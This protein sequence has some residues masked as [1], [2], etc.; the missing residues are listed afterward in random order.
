MK[1]YI[2]AYGTLK[3]FQKHYYQFEMD[4]KTNYVYT[5]C[6]RKYKMYELNGEPFIIETE[7][8]KDKIVGDLF[9]VKD[10]SVLEPIC[11]RHFSDDY[12]EKEVDVHEY[13]ALTWIMPSVPEEA[14]LNPFGVWRIK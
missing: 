12:I 9:E 7:D 5:C 1:T 3:R 13:K 8:E 10:V 2:F 4:K 6:L 14:V 11:N